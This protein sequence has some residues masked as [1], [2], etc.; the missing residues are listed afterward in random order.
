MKKIFSLSKILTT[1][2]LV[3][4]FIV[5]VVAMGIVGNEN[6]EIPDEYIGF[7]IFDVVIFG[8]IILSLWN[9]RFS[10]ATWPLMVCLI[11]F[12][13][14]YNSIY[15]ISEFDHI[16]DGKGYPFISWFYFLFGVLCLI[17]IAIFLFSWFF[18][19]KGKILR[20]IGLIILLICAIGW[21][22]ITV[23]YFN[24]NWVG[25][26]IWAIALCLI[27]LGLVTGSLY[28]ID[29]KNN[30]VKEESDAKITETKFS[31][32]K[33][34]STIFFSAYF[35]TFIVYFILVNI[36][37]PGIDAFE[38][39]IIIFNSIFVLAIILSLWVKRFNSAAKP[40]IMSMIAINLATNALH[41]ITTYKSFSESKDLFFIILYFVIGVIALIGI[42]SFALSLIFINNK[43]IFLIIVFSSL[44]V[45]TLG[46]MILIIYNLSTTFHIYGFL[47]TLS[48]ILFWLGL[49]TSFLYLV[50]FTKKESA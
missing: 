32:T 12:N 27:W 35:L 24:N 49:D 33:L 47:Y 28:I 39:S 43:K 23:Y 17:D 5:Y 6:G 8:T 34:L 7:F 16:I 42:I 4:G 3:A 36:K 50:K 9:S 45:M 46:Y 10:K 40:V 29:N 26:G 2:F 22:V 11:A 19:E 30:E 21:I 15:N 25:D 44:V 18:K 38:I 14:S 13:L 20:T 31:I 41:F 48:Y 37:H 1:I